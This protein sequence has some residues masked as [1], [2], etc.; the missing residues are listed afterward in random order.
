MVKP[1]SAKAELSD[2][3]HLASF[4]DPFMELLPDDGSMVDVQPRLGRLVSV[5][6]PIGRDQFCHTKSLQIQFL[7]VSMDFL[8]GRSLNA[9][10]DEVPAECTEFLQFLRKLNRG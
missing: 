4:A 1:I 8:F 5:E 9:L 3:D 6:P 2:I 10:E 7:D